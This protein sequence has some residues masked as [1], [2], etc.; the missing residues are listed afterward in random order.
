MLFY[1]GIMFEHE[2]FLR[3]VISCIFMH[4]ILLSQTYF[5]MSFSVKVLENTSENDIPDSLKER[6]QE[7][8]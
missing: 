6:L 8:K 4:V 7:E 1:I 2:S 3:H 5:H